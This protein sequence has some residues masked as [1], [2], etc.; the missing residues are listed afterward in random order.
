VKP[1][2]VKKQKVRIVKSKKSKIKIPDD[3]GIEV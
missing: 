2:E 1:V 3:F